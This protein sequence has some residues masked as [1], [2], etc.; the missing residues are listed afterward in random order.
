MAR[1]KKFRFDRA[2]VRELLRR[3][4]LAVPLLALVQLSVDE[5]RPL[6]DDARTHHDHLA[7]VLLQFRLDLATAEDRRV[8][9][10]SR[11]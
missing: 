11:R 10:R 3:D 1:K 8:L 4:N 9:L 7:E 2:R 6:I 5:L